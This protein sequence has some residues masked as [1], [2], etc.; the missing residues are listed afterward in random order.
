MIRL[1]V[2][3]QTKNSE[4]LGSCPPQKKQARGRKSKFGSDIHTPGHLEKVK[5]WLSKILRLS[6]SLKKFNTL[7]FNSCIAYL[8][9]YNFYLHAF[10]AMPRISFK[11]NFIICWKVP[12]CKFKTFIYGS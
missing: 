2:F 5:H 3:E 8:N 10:I 4:K 11:Y 1:L 9:Q 12:K 6:L 7:L